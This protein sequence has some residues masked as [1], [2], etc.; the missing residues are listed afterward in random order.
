MQPWVKKVFKVGVNLA[1]DPNPVADL[2]LGKMGICPL[3]SSEI[4]KKMTHF[5]I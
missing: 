3:K 4:G 5:M 1:S 2:R